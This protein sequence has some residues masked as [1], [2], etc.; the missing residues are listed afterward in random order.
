MNTVYTDSNN[1]TWNNN[2]ENFNNC[3]SKTTTIV[4]S[5]D[6]EERDMNIAKD[7]SR[8]DMFR[9]WSENYSLHNL[10]A[11][12]NDDD[13]VFQIF[14]PISESSDGIRSSLETMHEVKDV[15]DI[16]SEEDTDTDTT[17]IIENDN[18]NEK[19]NENKN[20]NKI[21][22]SSD[23][24][25]GYD[26]VAYN[27][28]ED[29]YFKEHENNEFSV[30]HGRHQ[31]VEMVDMGQHRHRHRKRITSDT[32]AITSTITLTTSNPNQTQI[33]P[34]PDL[35]TNNGANASVVSIHNSSNSS[36]NSKSISRSNCSIDD[37]KSSQKRFKCVMTDSNSLSQP[38]CQEHDHHQK[39]SYRNQSASTYDSPVRS[40][41]SS[42]KLPSSSYSSTNYTPTAIPI[43]S[44]STST[45]GSDTPTWVLTQSPSRSEKRCCLHNN[46]SASTNTIADTDDGDE[47]LEE[48]KYARAESESQSQSHSHLTL[49]TLPPFPPPRALNLPISKSNIDTITDTTGTTDTSYNSGEKRCRSRSLEESSQL[50]FQSQLGAVL[51]AD[52]ISDFDYDLDFN[53]RS[54]CYANNTTTTNI[55]TTAT[56]TTSTTSTTTI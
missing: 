15:S 22:N 36:N 13:S 50:H 18:D 5:E 35:T 29:G 12:F 1:D 49:M 40:T 28:D 32:T 42:S 4:D 37:H 51:C 11:I 21:P 25:N 46:T 23:N 34:A 41:V 55:A 27:G 24:V 2:V 45:N 7:R 30:T 47:G 38:H 39:Q 31:Q 43:N 56:T 26:G 53:H 3:N 52:V 20:K 10:H 48:T 17:I 9:E 44:S 19:E 16:D 14:T 8:S 33:I 6:E 54:I